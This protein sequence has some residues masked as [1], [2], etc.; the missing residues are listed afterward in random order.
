[1]Q[2]SGQNHVGRFST[3][4]EPPTPTGQEEQGWVVKRTPVIQAVISHYTLTLGDLR[5]DFYR[6]L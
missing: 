4:K 6:V 5:W 3:G 2:V 1:M